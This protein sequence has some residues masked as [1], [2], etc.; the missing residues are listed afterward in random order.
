MVH[1]NMKTEK[2]VLFAGQWMVADGGCDS[3]ILSV[4]DPEVTSYITR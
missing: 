1:F 3:G 4:S 2:F